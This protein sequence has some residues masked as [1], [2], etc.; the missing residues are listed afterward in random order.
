MHSELPLGPHG[1][2]P[3]RTGKVTKDHQIEIWKEQEIEIPHS[4][5]GLSR[6]RGYND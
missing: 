1:K 2:K 4:R 6:A 5:K 3:E